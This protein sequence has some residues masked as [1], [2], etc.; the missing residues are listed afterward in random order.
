MKGV[1][2][3]KTWQPD[4]KQEEYITLIM[5]MCTGCLMGTGVDRETLIQNL[6]LIADQIPK[7]KKQEGN[8]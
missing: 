6:K 7:N 2:P 5:S 1:M 3:R 4:K 8:E